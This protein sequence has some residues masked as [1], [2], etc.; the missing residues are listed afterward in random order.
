[1]QEETM[2]IEKLEEEL[3][4]LLDP[5][6]HC[7]YK[8][9]RVDNII[10]LFKPIIQNS[11]NYINLKEDLNDDKVILGMCNRHE[12]T[13]HNES[14]LDPEWGSELCNYNFNDVYKCG[15]Y[16]ALRS[17]CKRIDKLEKYNS[18]TIIVKRRLNND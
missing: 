2:G 4:D 9:N 18:D 15:Y 8:E 7:S 16:E 11:N 14:I 13:K 17:I 6:E 12:Y 3:F 1:M 5:N 10:K